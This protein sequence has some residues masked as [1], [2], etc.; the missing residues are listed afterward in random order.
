MKVT[1]ELDGLKPIGTTL[2]TRAATSYV[3][4]VRG[5]GKQTITLVTTEST[6]TTKT[7]SAKLKAEEGS[8]FEDSELLSVVQSNIVTYA[9]NIQVTDA[10]LNFDSNLQTNKNYTSSATFSMKVG[11]K[12]VDVKGA[13]ITYTTNNLKKSSKYYY[14][15]GIKSFTISNVSI[16]G[17]GINEDTEVKITITITAN[18]N[19]R[20][21]TYRSTIGGLSG[22]T[23]Q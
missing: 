20:T 13:D 14:I 12:D 6:S 7:C 2:E 15:T 16:S 23:Q 22:L 9:G 5:T 4:T 21:V 8:G 3:Y 11:D 10:N 17:E 18:G 19:S 1:L